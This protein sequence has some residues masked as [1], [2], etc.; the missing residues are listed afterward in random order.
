MPLSV[1][2]TQPYSVPVAFATGGADGLRRALEALAALESTTTAILDRISAEVST[3]RDR[4]ANVKERVAS[5]NDLVQQL[6]GR[7]Q[8]TT[9]LSAPRF[10]VDAAP[11]TRQLQFDVHDLQQA[12]VHQRVPETRPVTKDGSPDGCPPRLSVHSMDPA[13]AFQFD[14]FL[15]KRTVPRRLRGLGPLPQHLPSVSSLLLFNTALDPYKQYSTTVDPLEGGT[16]KAKPPAPAKRELAEAPQTVVSGDV[17]PK[18]HGLEYTFKPQ[19]G[20]VPEFCFPDALPGLTA[21]ADLPWDLDFSSW[22]PIAPSGIQ[23]VDLDDARSDVSSI[24]PLRRPPG[25]PPATGSRGPAP[26]GPPSAARGAP[27]P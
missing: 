1:N 27:P 13:K 16:R 12:A 2:A 14:F 9:L 21:V 11:V 4:L 7:A 17:L 18:V 23:S 6:S 5:A 15:P 19:L 26:P 20:D 10:P 3:Q 24:R 8:A 22:T 25:R